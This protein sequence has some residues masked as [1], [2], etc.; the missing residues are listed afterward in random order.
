MTELGGCA[1]YESAPSADS[2]FVQ[3]RGGLAAGFSAGS[4]NLAGTSERARGY[5]RGEASIGSILPLERD[6]TLSA[7]LYGA[8]ADNAPMQRSIF[9]SSADPFATFE[10]NFFRPKGAL[11]KQGDI[12]FLPLGGAGLRGFSPYVALERVAAANVD[13]AQRLVELTGATK[14]SIWASAFGDIAVAAARY[15]V[16]PDDVLADAGVGVAARGRFYDRNVKVRLDFPLFVNHA[17]LTRGSAAGRRGSFSARW[18]FSVG[19]LW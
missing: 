11:L 15:T 12:N 19:E 13:V 7:R 3:L 14:G 8:F 9:A 1:S 16:L 10:N 17:G 6:L 2:A 5:V 4:S 18:V